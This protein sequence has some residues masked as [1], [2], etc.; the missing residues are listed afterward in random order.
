MPNPFSPWLPVETRNPQITEIAL[1][2]HD[3]I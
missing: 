1:P 2:Y 3:T